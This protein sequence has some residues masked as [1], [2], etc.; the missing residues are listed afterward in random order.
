ML[1]CL[2]DEYAPLRVA[3]LIAV[4]ATAPFLTHSEIATL[5]LPRVVVLLADREQDVKQ[6]A[7]T[8]SQGL[9]AR[10]DP[11]DADVD[12]WDMSNKSLKHEL[13]RFGVDF[14]G[15]SERQ[16][17]I[18]LVLAT[19]FDQ[20]AAPKGVVDEEQLDAELEAALAEEG[21]CL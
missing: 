21:L 2:E 12:P 15:C 4:A 13:A 9:L 16:E 10:L 20:K 19:R 18:D 7:F 8:T 1:V 6:A 3:A 14:A 17:L 11:A 5:V